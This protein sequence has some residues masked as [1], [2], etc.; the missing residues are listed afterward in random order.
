MLQ[1]WPTLILLG[2]SAEIDDT[3]S[4]Y[5]SF[6]TA[7]DNK[8]Y[9]ANMVSM[10]PHYN[11][12]KAELTERETLEQSLVSFSRSRNLYAVSKSG[13]FV[14]LGGNVVR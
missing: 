4:Y 8:G 11:R 3:W 10:Q 1:L 14:A 13:R 6:E 9:E 12:G 7:N 2:Y 5:S